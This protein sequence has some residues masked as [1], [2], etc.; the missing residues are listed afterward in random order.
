[1]EKYFSRFFF[2]P[3][4]LCFFVYFFAAF[5][6]SLIA[7]SQFAYSV[8]PPMER[9]SQDPLYKNLTYIQNISNETIQKAMLY[10]YG[11]FAP[12][13]RMAEYYLNKSIASKNESEAAIY[14]FLAKIEAEE[15]IKSILEKR[16]FIFSVHLTLALLFGFILFHLFSKPAAKKQKLEP[17]K[18]IKRK[19]KG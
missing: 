10:S 14:A 11:F 4:Y 1:M 6:S 15:Q 7:F 18:L 13:L 9:Q 5:F 16:I 2:Y 8:Y 19:I 12:D 3:F 17:A